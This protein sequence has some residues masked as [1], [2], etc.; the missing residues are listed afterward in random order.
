MDKMVVKKL[1]FAVSGTSKFR[2]SQIYFDSG[3]GR[4]DVGLSKVKLQKYN[5]ILVIQAVS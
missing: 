2:E 1:F 4:R 5:P 3:S